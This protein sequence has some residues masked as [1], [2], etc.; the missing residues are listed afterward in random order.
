M[1]NLKSELHVIRLIYVNITHVKYISI[2]HVTLICI[3]LFV[4][5][6]ISVL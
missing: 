5:L 6:F 1:R 3:V 4:C 2:P